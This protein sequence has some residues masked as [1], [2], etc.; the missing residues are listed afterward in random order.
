MNSQASRTLQAPQKEK[1]KAC[2][3]W[4]RYRHGCDPPVSQI[5]PPHL[6]PNI[7]TIIVTAFLSFAQLSFTAFSARATEDPDTST[8]ANE[9]LT[10]LLIHLD[11]A[12]HFGSSDG[13]NLLVPPGEYLVEP[14]TEG[15]PR[16][17]FWHEQGTVT[18]QATRTTHDQRVKTP[19]AY[20]VQE[21]DYEDLYHMVVFMPDGTALEATGSLS[22]IQTRGDLHGGRHYQLDTA[23]GV[24]QFG[25]GRQGRRLP[26][27]QPNIT[28]QYRNGSGSRESE[29]EMITLQALMSQRQAAQQSTQ[30]LINGQKGGFQYEEA[31]DR[32]G[33]DYARHLEESANS[34]RARC[35]GEE[36][37]QAFTF[38]K[39]N[40]VS[41]QGQ[42]FLKRSKPKP[43]NNRCCVSGTR[44]SNEQKI[45]GNIGR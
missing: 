8:L 4:N 3:P 44:K 5:N 33:D 12:L 28:A 42:C 27:G 24:V 18:L 6:S 10:P 45:I 25:N 30:A 22:G 41:V 21:D 37:C 20:L 34:C 2:T 26:T 16:L 19:E 15:E 29:L 7:A 9:K 43:V 13:Q 39:P 23:T 1:P 35:A 38:V 11:Q 14:I 17:V 36:T 31:T 32:P 40:P